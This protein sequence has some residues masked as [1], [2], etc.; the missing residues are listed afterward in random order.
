MTTTAPGNNAKFNELS[1]V[2]GNIYGNDDFKTKEDKRLDQTVSELTTVLKRAFGS[3]IDKYLPKPGGPNLSAL[4]LLKGMQTQ[5]DTTLPVR[6]EFLS[7]WGEIGHLSH[8]LNLDEVFVANPDI[9]GLVGKIGEL[10]DLKE[11]DEIKKESRP[12][13]RNLNELRDQIRAKMA[14]ERK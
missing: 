3:Y 6:K 13:D 9:E 2:L 12:G 10:I 1:S 7:L 11:G 8:Q 14:R 4:R 5:K